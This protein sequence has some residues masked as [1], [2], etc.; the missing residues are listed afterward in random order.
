MK[1]RHNP[2]TQTVRNSWEFKPTSVCRL[3]C[4]LI[5]SRYLRGG[6]FPDFVIAFALSVEHAAIF[7]QDGANMARQTRQ[8]LDG[9]LVAAGKQTGFHDRWKAVEKHVVSVQL[10]KLR[11]HVAQLGNER[12]EAFG[13][14][15]QADFIADCHIEIGVSVSGN[16]YAEHVLLHRISLIC[17]IMSQAHCIILTG[18]I[19]IMRT[20]HQ[21]SIWDKLRVF[22]SK[23]RSLSAT[24]VLK[25]REI[26]RLTN[27]SKVAIPLLILKILVVLN[28]VA[29]HEAL[30]HILEH[31]IWAGASAARPFLCL[32]NGLRRQIGKLS[33]VALDRT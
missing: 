1:N 20:M 15:D 4:A 32:G 3:R 7:F 25:I 18:R 24:S 6:V 29:N 28:L 12:I 2:V 13:F 19:Q 8:G 26:V 33:H 27:A 11:H 17:G 30:Q 23:L 14:C 16:L 21:I 22:Q 10:S 31:Q 9:L 5:E